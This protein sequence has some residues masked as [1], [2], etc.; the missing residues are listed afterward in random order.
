MSAVS[1]STISA[2]FREE[3]RRRT[4]LSA[5]PAIWATR[6]LTMGT[7]SRRNKSREGR[8]T[9]QAA[10]PSF[11]PD[12]TWPARRKPSDEIAGLLSVVPAGLGLGH[13]VN[14]DALG[15]TPSRRLVF[16]RLLGA[17]AV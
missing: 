1:E 9:S 10:H 13:F 2:W 4:W 12:G 11:V 16:Q 3:Q 7:N 17:S 15:N 6:P 5:A 8:K 14:T